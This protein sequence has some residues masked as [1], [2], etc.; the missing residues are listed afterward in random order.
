MVIFAAPAA[1]HI[2]DYVIIVATCYRIGNSLFNG[3][4]KV[5][6]SVRLVIHSLSQGTSHSIFCMC[7]NLLAVV[8]LSVNAI[9]AGFVACVN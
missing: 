9:P 5:V 6:C 8:R 4:R 7:P 1:A 3:E 2:A